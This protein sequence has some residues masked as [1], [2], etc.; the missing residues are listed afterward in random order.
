MEYSW[1]NTKL[2]KNNSSITGDKSEGSFGF[3]YILKS[4]KTF[5]SLAEKS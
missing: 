2:M 3:F 5:E 1:S 4:V